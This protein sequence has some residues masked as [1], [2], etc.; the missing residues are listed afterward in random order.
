MPRSLCGLP[1]QVGGCG[2]HGPER[3]SSRY[4]FLSGRGSLR[5]LRGEQ[6][7]PGYKRAR[8]RAY[9]PLREAHPVDRAGAPW[10]LSSGQGQWDNTTL[11][12]F[13][14]ETDWERLHFYDANIELMEGWTDRQRALLD[15]FSRLV[16]KGMLECAKRPRFNF[17][18]EENWYQTYLVLLEHFDPKT[19][20]GRSS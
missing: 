11:R 14:E 8:P 7:L 20:T 3:G 16:Q 2:G 10:A 4:P 1:L 5:R 9:P 12:Y 13:L 6:L 19:R 17:M 15:H 18:D